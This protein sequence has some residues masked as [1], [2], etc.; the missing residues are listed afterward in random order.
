MIK[1]E[2]PQNIRYS[3]EKTEFDAFDT[4]AKN[5]HLQKLGGDVRLELGDW[6]TVEEV[7]SEGEPT[8]NRRMFQVSTVDTVGED[9]GYE[10][11]GFVPP[12]FRTLGAIYNDFVTAS[13]V[14]DRHADGGEEKKELYTQPT[15]TPQLACPDL[16]NMGLLELLN[17]DLW[18]H[19]RFSVTLMLELQ[20]NT[21]DRVG[22]GIADAL[23]LTYL[24]PDANEKEVVFVELDW[25]GLQ[26]GHAINVL[27]DAPVTPCTLD[28]LSDVMSSAASAAELAGHD[29]LVSEEE[30]KQLLIEARAQGEDVS[31][32]EKALLPLDDGDDEDEDDEGGDLPTE[33][34]DRLMR[35]RQ[36]DR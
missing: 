19:G 30:L 14:V 33:L 23:V 21:E 31:E 8:G 3:C 36:E 2:A 15:Y 28:A 13:F 17:A 24:Q 16:L 7:T 6:I 18:P 22:V 1:A 25:S 5:F 12:D 27:T 4:G 10:V 35:L 20:F 29:E 11:L 9:T 32:L 26:S 34:A